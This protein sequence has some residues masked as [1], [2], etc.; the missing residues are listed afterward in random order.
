MGNQRTVIW[1]I[2]GPNLHALGTRRTDVYGSKTLAE[3][4]TAWMAYGH[5][6]GVSVRCE[7]S[8]HEGQLIDWIHEARGSQGVILNAG[9]FTHYSVAIRD[10]IES[11]VPTPVIEVHLS[12]VHARESFRAH[13][14][15]APVC[16]GQLTGFGEAGYYLAMRVLTGQW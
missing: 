2:N 8:N 13:S 11:I 7:Q 14:V 3:L 6:L 9:A 1:V 5:N 12:N 10:A 15:M 4:T 16:S